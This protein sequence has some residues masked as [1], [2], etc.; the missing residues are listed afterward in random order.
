[1][2]SAAAGKRGA[3]MSRTLYGVVAAAAFG[4]LQTAGP[5][6]S[7]PV[8]VTNPS[9]ETAEAV[10]GFPST[11]GD[12]GVD[13]S[14]IVTAQNGIT[15]LDGIRMLHFVNTGVTGGGGGSADVGQAIDMSPHAALIAAGGATFSASAYFNRVAGTS[16]TDTEFIVQLRSFNTANV[17]S[18]F[19][20]GAGATAT[21]NASLISDGDVSTWEKLTAQ[22]VLPIDTTFVILYLFAFENVSPSSSP[23]LDGHYADLVS[24]SI[25]SPVP[26]PAAAWLFG[27]AMGMMGLLGWRKRRRALSAG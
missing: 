14:E 22:L 23:E 26:L 2:F 6:L 9:F 3:T 1:M 18:A 7:A 5:A 11:F 21:I 19:S 17:L 24:A 16:Q 8:T 12:W 10:G 15:P 13:L 20:T 4:V 27:T 25:T